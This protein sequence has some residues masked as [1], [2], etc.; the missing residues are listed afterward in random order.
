MGLFFICLTAFTASCLTFFSGFGLATIL[1]PVF[2][3]FFPVDTA[4][5]LTAIVHFLNNILKF[6]LLSRK[7]SWRI[8]LKFGLPAFAAAFLGAKV[9]FALGSIP[10]IYTYELFGKIM[11][12]TNDIAEQCYIISIFMSP[13]DVHINRSPIY[14]TVKLVK[15]TKGKFFKA[16]DFE[17]SFNNEKNEIII[18]N[19]NLKINIEPDDGDVIGRTVTFL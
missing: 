1:T 13:F 14:G 15:H 12:L 2:I 9:L 4:I 3:I 10:Q 19:K 18:Q 7:A 6:L 5:A 16:Y 17:K 11:T 8:V